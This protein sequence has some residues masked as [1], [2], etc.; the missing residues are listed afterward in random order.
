MHLPAGVLQAAVGGE[1]ARQ[2]QATDAAFS[3]SL[4]LQRNSYAMFSEARIPLLGSPESSQGIERLTLALA[5]RFDHSND[6]GGK[7]TWQ[8]GLLWRVTNTLS[9]SGSFGQSYRA[10]RL[11]EIGGPQVATPN[12]ILGGTDP[13]RGGEPVVYGLTF[14]TGPNF[15]L[16][17]ET[18]RSSTAGLKYQSEASHG[19]CASLSW[20]ELKISNFIG[21]PN[22]QV[23]LDNPALYPGA[24]VRAPATPQDQQLGFPGV[25][26]QFNDTFYNFGDVRVTGIDADVSY[27]VDTRIGQFTP[28]LSVANVYQWQS[29]LI[30]GAPT[31][32]AVSKANFD[33][34]GWA[35]RWKGTAAL[36]WNRGPLS[37][38]I[39]GRYIGRYLDY[40]LYVPNSNEIGNSWIVDAAA[41]VELGHAFAAKSPWL[42]HA[43]IALGVVNAFDKTPRFSYTPYWYD[44]EQY[45]LRGRFMHLSVG[46]RL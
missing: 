11:S 31:V 23:I 10:P 34:P 39:T 18:G 15:N 9:V 26:T 29:A 14:V 44:V 7:S 28:S 2:E 30:P 38:N 20:Y 37:M 17:P 33:G 36:A 5:G 3:Q 41:R 4:R 45:D 43:Y 12:A 16:H 22:I 25:I 42:E 13:D 24:V 46:F 21:A 8:G 35:P 40:Q 19:L 32:D 6:F 27:S 1:Y